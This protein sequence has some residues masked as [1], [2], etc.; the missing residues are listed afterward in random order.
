MA[1]ADLLP[2]KVLDTI[3]G[4]LGS[5]FVPLLG[6]KG[7]GAGKVEIKES[8]AVRL[9]GRDAV[10]KANTDI[11]KLAV[12]TGQWHHQV[13]YDSQP[14]A[15][16]RSMPTGPADT[17]WQVTSLFESDIAKRI[18]EA[19]EWVDANVKDDPLVRLLICPA[20]YVHA[21]WL[22]REGK[23]QLLVVDMPR[24]FEHLKRL[25][26]Y[27]SKEFL[28]RLAKENCTSCRG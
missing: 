28:E 13:R 12:S 6:L 23:S 27:S 25:T 7:P 4:E 11:G 24:G 2:A 8:F 15:F 18:D 3:A 5:Q 21:F 14:K 17:D 22:L 20:Y 9:L 16:A 10:T 26:L 19:I 1:H